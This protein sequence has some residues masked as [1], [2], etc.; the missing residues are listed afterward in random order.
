MFE[1][2]ALKSRGV[3]S[4]A[5]SVLRRLKCADRVLKPVLDVERDL[6]RR[7]GKVEKN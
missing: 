2:P 1:V 6:G 4:R 7:K 3:R 5:L